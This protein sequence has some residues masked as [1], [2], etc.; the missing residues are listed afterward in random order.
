MSI[1]TPY[2]WQR[3]AIDFAVDR[4]FTRGEMGAALF[5]DPGWG[6]TALTLEVID[7]LKQFTGLGKVLVVAPIRPLYAVWPKEL[8]KWSYDLSHVIVHGEAKWRRQ[9]LKIKRD[10]YLINPENIAWLQEQGVN[11]FEM[12]VV[13]ES[14]YFANWSAKRTKA[15]RR[16]LLD[17]PKRIILTGTPTAERLT[18]IY[19]QLFICDNGA[20]LGKNITA[21]RNS[22][23]YKGG[24]EGREWL[25][26]QGKEEELYKAIGGVCFHGGLQ[27]GF[28]PDFRENQIKV[29]LGEKAQRAYMDV[30]K[31]L[32]AELESGQTLTA[33]SAGVSYGLCR[34]MASGAC[35]QRSENGSRHVHPLHKKKADALAELYEELHGKQLLIAYQYEHSLDRIKD[36]IPDVVAGSGLSAKQ[37]QSLL[38]RWQRREVGALA[39]QCQSMSHGID[40]LQLGCN[41][42]CWFDIPDSAGI[43]RQL[44]DRVHRN[45]ATGQVRVHYLVAR[46]TIDVVLMRR[47]NDKD[48]AQKTLLESLKDDRPN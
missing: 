1:F 16:M 13:D 48:E 6:K 34:Q 19:A 20:T 32:Y 28:L 24:F 43:R 23:C 21:F 47:L 46:N 8:K 22:Y 25:F 44:N 26:N 17:I 11:D 30:E 15:L 7:T 12:I 42:V 27:E 41:D 31:K 38:E 40:G 36:A 45:G 10:L 3:P 2:D 29:R 14:T 33:S 35:Y 18:D 39:V 5:L 4:M 9:A 37:F